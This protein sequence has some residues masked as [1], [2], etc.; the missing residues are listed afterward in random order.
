MPFFPTELPGLLIYE[1]VIH[2]DERGYFYESYNEQSFIQYGLH[3][4][5]VQD[6]QARSTF[7][8]LRGLHYQLEPY[9]QT[10]L[11]RVLEGSILDVAVDDRMGSPT[12]GQTYSL[13]LSV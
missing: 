8:V 6:N 13:I 1:P 4:Q 3:H 9:A 7:G 2:R 11:I 5:F 12:F 10:K